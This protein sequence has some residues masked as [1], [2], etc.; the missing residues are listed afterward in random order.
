METK[1]TVDLCN[2]YHKPQGTAT[3]IEDL[4][5]SMLLLEHLKAHQKQLR[6]CAG[7]HL[8]QVTEGLEPQ[9]SDKADN[10]VTVDDAPGH[11]I[12]SAWMESFK[13]PSIV[14]SKPERGDIPIGINDRLPR[15]FLSDIFSKATSPEEWQE[16]ILLG[17]IFLLWT[18]YPS[19]STVTSLMEIQRQAQKT[20]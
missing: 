5:K 12:H 13:E 17:R 11:D 14:V 2:Q 3:M 7:Y 9:W 19:P 20:V 4:C 10:H 15:D 6:I 8:V 18:R 16:M 1:V